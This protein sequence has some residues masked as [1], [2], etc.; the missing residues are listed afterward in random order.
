MKA[1]FTQTSLIRAAATKISAL[2]RKIKRDA[3]PFALLNP[4]ECGQNVRQIY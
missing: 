1:A 4:L 2:T 3:V